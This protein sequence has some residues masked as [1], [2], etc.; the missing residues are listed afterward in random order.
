MGVVDDNEPPSKR[1]KGPQ[2]VS[3][4]DTLHKQTASTSSGDSMARPLSLQ[5]DDDTIGLKGI[6]KKH[7]F[8]KIINR[9]LYSLGYSK[10]ATILEE[11]SG[12]P[13]HSSA[14]TLFMQQVLDGKWDECLST[15][16]NIGLTDD[17]VVKSASFLI[18]EQKFLELLR[19]GK[20]MAALLTLRNEIVPLSINGVRVHELSAYIIYPSQFLALGLSDQDT[21]IALSR[22]CC[23]EKLQKLLPAAIMIPESRL[24]HLVEQALDVQRGACVFHN[25]LNSELSLYTD[26]QCG[27]DQIPSKTLQTLQEHKDEIWFLQFS[28]NGKYL[29][30]SSKDQTALLWEVQDDGQLILKHTLSGHLGAVSTISWRHDDSQLLTC[31]MEEAVRRWDVSSDKSICLWDLEGNILEYWKGYRTENI[32]D[33]ALTSDGKIIISICRGNTLLLFNRESRCERI[34]EEEDRITSFSLSKDNKFLLVNLVNQEIH[35]WRITGDPKI[36]SKFKGH[37]RTRF[38]VRSCF[39]GFEQS[40][41]ASGS[42]DSQ[43]YIWHRGTGELL[44]K[45]PG[46]SGAVNCV[47]WHPMNPHMLASASDDCTIRIWGLDNLK[48]KGTST[49]SNGKIHHQPNGRT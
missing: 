15:L 23:L 10:T 31:G 39:G 38:L 26:H 47:S 19:K 22:A 27:R 20:H 30:S 9:A 1:L 42:E 40:F 8:V 48:C 43:V 14:V 18:L 13:L 34:I 6:I 2:G 12:I 29:A 16:H 7:E 17:A 49:Q 32:S 33:M 35:L 3:K 25:T 45:L 37:K 46:H 36:V 21:D 44:A 4:E 28:H 24:E 41:I 11:E 5:R